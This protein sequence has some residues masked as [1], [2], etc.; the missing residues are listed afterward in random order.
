M[1]SSTKAAV[2]GKV[3]FYYLQYKHLCAIPTILQEVGKAF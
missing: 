3:R 1:T 2:S